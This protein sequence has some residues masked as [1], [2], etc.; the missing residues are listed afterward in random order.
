MN[1]QV[2]YADLWAQLRRL[3]YNCDRLIDDNKHRV[4]EHAAAGSLL[5]LADYPPDQPVHPQTLY[6][7]R[8]ELDNFGLWSRAEFDRWVDQLTQAN[9][10]MANGGNGARQTPKPRKGLPGKAP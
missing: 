3:G 8:L 1:S 5:S 9:A 7:V 10:T 4:C 6:G 2:R